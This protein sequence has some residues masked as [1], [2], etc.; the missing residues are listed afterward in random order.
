MLALLAFEIPSWVVGITG[1]IVGL[2][3]ASLREF[4]S[5]RGRLRERRES[6]LFSLYAPLVVLTG[7]SADT[8]EYLKESA[9][10]E[11]PDLS[12]DGRFHVLTHLPKLA[13]NPTCSAL[14]DEIREANK[15][16]R[17]VIVEHGGR[18][19]W[20]DPVDPLVKFLRHQTAFELSVGRARRGEPVDDQSEYPTVLDKVVRDGYDDL[21]KRLGLDGNGAWYS[22]AWRRITKG[23][24][25]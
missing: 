7:H 13:E 3:L 16:I 11:F 4:L 23:R 10:D 18:L 14:L 2:L 1:V 22:R 19:L 20:D 5:W 15:Q 17:E 12:E 6:Q 21:R 8:K 24:I 25:G 9:L